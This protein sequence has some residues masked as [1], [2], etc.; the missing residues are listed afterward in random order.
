MYDGFE[1]TLVLSPMPTYAL[2]AAGRPRGEHSRHLATHGFAVRG[3]VSNHESNIPGLLPK[4]ISCFDLGP[5]GSALSMNGKVPWFGQQ[6][7][8]D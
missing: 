5:C 2:Q 6:P 8:Q 1:K 4:S 7:L 3:E